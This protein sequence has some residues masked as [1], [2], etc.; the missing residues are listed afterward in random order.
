[1]YYLP[2]NT[3]DSWDTDLLEAVDLSDNFWECICGSEWIGPWLSSLGDRNT[4][5][6]DLGCLMFKCDEASEKQREQH[7][8]LITIIATCLAIVAFLFLLAIAYLYIQ[9][10]CYGTVKIKRMQSD[11]VRLIPSMESLS[12][13]NPFAP[14][15][16]KP[17]VKLD[18]E[19]TTT[20]KS[21][22]TTTGTSE[23]ADKSA[24]TGDSPSKGEK[25]RV[26]FGG[27]Y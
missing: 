25:K 15:N 19:L 6:G 17:I 23:D 9:E 20:L 27:I 24:K 21:A 22:T 8:L 2:E 3:F 12:Y 5:T 26:R 4:P 7:S 11:M 13:P 18:P 1:M 14:Q 16:G 10:N